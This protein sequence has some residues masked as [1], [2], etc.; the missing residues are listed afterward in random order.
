MAGRGRSAAATSLGWRMTRASSAR[1][2]S[3][4]A[5]S[6]LMSSSAMAGCS[7]T[8]SLK[9]TMSCSRAAMSMLAPAA[10]ALEGRVDL[11]A[12]HHA[13]SQRRRERRQA[14]GA[15]LED[16]DE[17][18]AEAEEQ[19]GP[20]LGVDAAA[21][22]ELVAVPVD[23]RLHR[24]ALEVP[25]AMLLR[26]RPARCP[27]RPSRTASASGRSRRTPPTSDLWVIVCETSLTTTG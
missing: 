22:D 27:R 17:L 19:D 2:R 26:R 5:S 12:L 13:A 3:G 24:D 11:G 7:T 20:E 23:H 18:A 15:V 6:G 25:G 14:E 9:R 16:L 10:H 1:S 4:E 21:D 8:S